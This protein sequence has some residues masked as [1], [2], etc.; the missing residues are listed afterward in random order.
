MSHFWGQD[1]YKAFSLFS[2]RWRTSVTVSVAHRRM[3]CRAVCKQPPT[4]NSVSGKGQK[5]VT[6]EKHKVRECAVHHIISKPPVICGVIGSD[7]AVISLQQIDFFINFFTLFSHK[8]K[9]IHPQ[10]PVHGATYFTFIHLWW[11][12][13]FSLLSICYLLASFDTPILNW[14][15]RNSS[16]F[17]LPTLF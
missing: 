12:T 5:W 11:I 4:Q 7:S 8:W 2:P 13:C 10:Q 6:R 3:M 1:Q 9:T 15:R 17:S 14:W 16:S